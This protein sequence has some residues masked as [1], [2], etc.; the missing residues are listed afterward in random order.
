[1]QALRMRA[2][3]RSP[4][5]GKE[6]RM[7]KSRVGSTER[8]THG[9]SE[10]TAAE[11]TNEKT[12]PSSDSV[13]GRRKPTTLTMYLFSRMIPD[14]AAQKASALRKAGR[15]CH[16]WQRSPGSPHGMLHACIRHPA[17]RLNLPPS[18]AS[19]ARRAGT[20]QSCSREIQ[21]RGA[22]GAG[23]RSR[24]RRRDG[25]WRR[26]RVRVLSAAACHPLARSASRGRSIL[27]STC[28]RDARH[29]SYRT[30]ASQP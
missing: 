18:R 17:A 16:S 6:R 5:T 11:A 3:G 23:W 13:I 27:A 24:G 1:M 2:E 10:V 22:S 19:R 25:E 8:G 26:E 9:V 7:L 29:S 14:D 15:N 28:W 20:W 12:I 30:R 21:R 4:L